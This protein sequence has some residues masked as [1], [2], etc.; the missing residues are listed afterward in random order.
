M[1]TLCEVVGSVI[2]E[3]LTELWPPLYGILCAAMVAVFVFLAYLF[4]PA[5]ETAKAV[6][7]LLAAGLFLAVGVA[8]LK[9]GMFK[10][11]RKKDRRPRK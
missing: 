10:P 1:E 6:I 4:F 2:V 9:N 8:G 11:R 7:S 5:G 3:F